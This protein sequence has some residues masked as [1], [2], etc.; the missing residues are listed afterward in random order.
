M[1]GVMGV[2]LLGIGQADGRRLY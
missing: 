2:P 1:P